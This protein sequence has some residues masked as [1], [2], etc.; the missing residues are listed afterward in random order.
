[1]TVLQSIVFHSLTH[2]TV[3]PFVVVC[4]MLSQQNIT[5]VHKFLQ[6]KNQYIFCDL[7]APRSYN[8]GHTESAVL[9]HI[10]LLLL[11]LIKSVNHRNII[12]PQTVIVW[13]NRYNV[14][15]YFTVTRSLVYIRW[16]NMLSAL[17]CVLVQVFINNSKDLPNRK[18]SLF[19]WVVTPLHCFFHSSSPFSLPSPSFMLERWDCFTAFYGCIVWESEAVFSSPSCPLI[20]TLKHP[21]HW[22]RRT[23]HSLFV[24]LLNTGGGDTSDHLA[25]HLEPDNKWIVVRCG[26]TY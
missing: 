22:R 23:N 16:K 21:S 11:T 2:S 3:L 25:S 10:L 8:T 5:N 17:V 19:A 4:L 18:D 26:C 1:M 15:T 12:C 14:P 24:L 6:T 20:Q 13:V 7:F 9:R